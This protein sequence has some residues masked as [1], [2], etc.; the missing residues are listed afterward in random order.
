MLSKIIFRYFCDSRL[1]VLATNGF[2]RPFDVDATGYT[3]SEA[4]CM[5]FLQ[6]AKTAKRVYATL[7]YSKTNCDG[8]KTEGITY[9]SGSMQQKLLSEFYDEIGI[10]PSSLAYV[11]AHS[12]GTVVGD[13]EECAA[14]DN[15]FC[16]NRTRPLPVGSVK[17]NIGHSESTSGAC[18]ITKVLLAFETGLVAPNINFTKIRPGIASLEEGRL[19]VCTDPVKLEGKL[20]GVNSFGFG[21]ANA[22]AL[23]RGNSKEKVNHGAPSDNLPRLVTWSGR[24]EEAISALMDRVQSQPLDTEFIAL[25]HN[26][27]NEETPGYIFRGFG[28]FRQGTAKGPAECLG[29]EVQHYSGLKRPVVWVFSGMGSQWCEMGASLMDIPLFRESVERCHQTLKPHGLDL[30]SIIT[31]SDPTTFDNIL[32]SFVG[33]AAI[34]IAIVDILR[35][36]EIPADYFIGHSVGELG[37]AYADGCFTAEQMILAAYSRGMSSLETKKIRGSMAAIGLGYNKIKH[38]VPAAIEVACHNGPDSCTISGPEADVAKFVAELKSQGIFAKEVPCSNIAYHS[39]YI[40]DMGPNLLARLNKVIPEPKRR[41]SKWLSSSVPKSRWDNEDSQWSSAKY[42]TNNLLSSV[43]FEEASTLLPKNALTIEIAPHGLLQAILK[44]SMPGATHV[45]LTK[46]GVKDNTSF[47]L[48]A[49]GKLFNHGLIVPVERIYPAVQF[50]VS[51]GTSMIAPIVRWEHSED[52]FVTK[53]ELQ[54]STRSGERKV[55]VSLTD[56]D[57]DFISGHSI[58]GWLHI[59]SKNQ[60]RHPN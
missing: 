49:L 38:K 1:G 32:H 45:P 51:R 59:S 55:K 43:L 37:C 57:Y 15:V 12:T 4:I 28:L 58:D 44:K 6:K 21:G 24:T 47:L 19:S 48:T 41:S 7:L 18:S 5:L 22:H 40:A 16:K 3:R 31:S 25:L 29:K 2:C 20:I 30:I 27:Q 42:H 60:N 46:R 53:F 52:W 13:P 36:L 8:Y 26:I 54:R 23:L 9:P 11:E 10:D 14:L 35:V 34:Q 39:R 56:Q 17:S 50:P 33:I